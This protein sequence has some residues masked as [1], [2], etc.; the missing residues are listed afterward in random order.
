MTITLNQ[1]TRGHTLWRSIHLET[2]ITTCSH[3]EID[4]S[5]FSDACKSYPFLCNTAKKVSHMVKM[6]TL[7]GHSK[8][9]GRSGNCESRNAGT[10][11]GSKM[12][13][14]PEIRCKVRLDERSCALCEGAHGY[15]RD[16]QVY[17]LAV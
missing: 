10:R 3:I 13:S 15:S 6:Q 14:A 16:R 17:L 11:N 8:Q 7:H 12:R 4:N 2:D 5:A 1:T 9:S